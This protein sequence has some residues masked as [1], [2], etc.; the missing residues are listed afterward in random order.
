MY[1][2]QVIDSQGVRPD[3]DKIRAIQDLKV[4]ENISEVR[5]L[6]GSINH[7][8]KYVPHMKNLRKPLDYLLR[9]DH[10]F[11]WTTQCQSSLDEFK[12]ILTSDLLLTHYNPNLPIHVA[13]DASSHGIGAVI[14]H[15]FP[16]GTMKAIHHVSRS[17]TSAEK[18]YSQ[19]EKEGLAL[20]FAVQRFHKM[21]FGRKFTLH[22][23]HK[24][25]LKI[26]GS[27]TGIPVYT[28][29][30]LQRWALILLAYDFEIKYT[31]TNEFGH[32]DVL[33][34]LIQ[35]HEKPSDDF[36]IASISMENDIRN[37]LNDSMAT[38]PVSFNMVV[39]ATEKDS[40]LQKVLQQMNHGWPENNK[41]IDSTL[42][43]F[44]NRRDSLSQIDGVILF[45]SRI[46]VPKLYQHRILKQL[47]RE[48]ISS[49]RSKSIARSYVYWP[50]IDKDI[51]ALKEML[52]KLKKANISLSNIEIPVI[53][54]NGVVFTNTANFQDF[55]DKLN[56]L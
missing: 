14:Y 17:L 15:T 46:I 45:N 2:G 5:S 48:H 20:I 39:Q 12:R 32:A 54:N 1:L 31:N 34:R 19:I 16:E 35:Q 11:K 47:H 6:L 9:K 8:G 56:K 10:T 25:L 52:D 37:D 30:R 28:A 4:P 53:D 26:F 42:I 24:P 51:E 50:Y 41:N 13:A 43:P 23:D 40:T 44:Y 18:N 38:L 33:S 27:K 3:A 36:V 7:Y 21:L 29:N 55:L 49:E 22:T